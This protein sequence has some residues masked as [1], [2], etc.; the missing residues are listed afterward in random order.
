MNKIGKD[1]EY[2]GKRS[3]QVPY[4]KFYF[5]ALLVPGLMEIAIFSGHSLSILQP[6]GTSNPPPPFSLDK[7]WIS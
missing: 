3:G 4:C 6:Q 7:S 1:C 2:Y 5:V